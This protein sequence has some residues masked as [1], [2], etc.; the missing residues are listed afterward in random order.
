MEEI[1]V[2]FDFC[3]MQ[4]TD[5]FGVLNL[6]KQMFGEDGKK[7]GFLRDLTELILKSDGTVVKVDESDPYAVMTVVD[8][9]KDL[10]SYF[11]RSEKLEKYLKNGCWLIND[12][13]IN[14]PP[15][16]VP[17]LLRLVL[18][19]LELKKE[20]VLYFC[21][22]GNLKCLMYS[23]RYVESPLELEEKAPS[24]RNKKQKIEN[25]EFY[26]QPEDEILQ[27][28]A[29]EKLDVEFDQHSM[30][31]DAR[32][33]FQDQGIEPFR[34]ILILKSDIL[35]DIQTELTTFLQ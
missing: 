5:Y 6:V 34:R 19:D 23:G 29:L 14:M 20:F 12:R 4:E 30:S 16:L 25:L 22:L 3:S 8:L 15:Q 11:N 10:M 7:L 18:E 1:Q 31:S 2:D 33:T 9:N 26:F 13:L 35:Q 21:K 27:K 28:Y 17:N 24:K 32:R